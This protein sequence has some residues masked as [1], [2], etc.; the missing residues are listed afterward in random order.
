MYQHYIRGLRSP[1]V[2]H[3][4]YLSLMIIITLFFG[5]AIFFYVTRQET[6]KAGA[7]A[8]AF[9]VSRQHVM[10]QSFSFLFL[11]TKSAPSAITDTAKM[12]T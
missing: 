3:C 8:P 6:A 7:S 12:V 10:C 2:K 5:F 1:A 9:A 11:L 4:V